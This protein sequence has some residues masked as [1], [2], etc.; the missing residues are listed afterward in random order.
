[1]GQR[2]WRGV[3]ILSMVGMAWGPSGLYGQAG[4]SGESPQAG[5]FSRLRYRSIGP[6]TGGR[7]CRVA[8]VPG[9]PLI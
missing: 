9:N 8:G 7:V 1:M 4:G 3:V 6:A 5:P 2:T